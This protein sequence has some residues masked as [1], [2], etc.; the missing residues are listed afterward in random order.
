MSLEANTNILEVASW[1]ID[2]W[3]GE[4]IGRKLEL[5]IHMN[6]LEQLEADIKESTK[7]MFDLEYSLEPTDAD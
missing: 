7:L 4:G 5:D 3:A 1:H 6:D 2:Y